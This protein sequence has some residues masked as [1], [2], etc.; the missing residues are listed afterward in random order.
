MIISPAGE[1]MFMLAGLILSNNTLVG[2]IVMI[3]LFTF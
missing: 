3:P 1:L 2:F